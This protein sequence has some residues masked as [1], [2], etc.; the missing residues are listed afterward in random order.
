MASARS[1]LLAAGLLLL[2]FSTTGVPVRGVQNLTLG[3][4]PQVAGPKT[5]LV[6]KPTELAWGAPLYVLRVAVEGAPRKKGQPVSR[7]LAADVIDISCG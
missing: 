5:R 6:T 7:F 4:I 2:F 3:G 1:R